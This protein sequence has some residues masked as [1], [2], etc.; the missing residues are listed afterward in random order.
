[1]AET[2][3]AGGRLDLGEVLGPLERLGVDLVDVLG[4]R[5][6][7]GEPRRLGGHLEAADRRVVARRP[8][9]DLAV[10]GSPASSVAVTAEASSLASLAFCSRLAGASTRAYAGAPCSRGQ[11][12]VQLA[13]RL[14]G[15]RLDLAGQ[16]GEQDAVLVGGPGAAVEGEERCAGR[17]LAAEA[18]LAGAQPGH[19]PLEADRHLDQRAAEARPRPGRSSTRRPA[20]CRSRRRD[21]SRRGGRTGTGWR[22]RGSAFGFIR[23]ASGV[24]MPCRSES[25]SL[26]VEMS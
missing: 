2:T 4:A 24:T 12:G 26:P 16:Q 20:S 13:R 21:A 11:L 5:R 3:S 1:M 8:W 25:A 15:H 17:L 10:I 7:G 14:A 6:A 19:E 23:P 18:D 9:S 22:P